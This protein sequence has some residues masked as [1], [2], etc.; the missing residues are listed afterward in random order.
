MPAR[1]SGSPITPAG[2]D[3]ARSARRS[4]RHVGWP[5]GGRNCWPIKYFYVVFT[6]PH[7][8]NP[9]AQGNPRVIYDLKQRYSADDASRRS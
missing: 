6:L 1:R 7:A 3:T 5:R 9:L 2:S 8:L 4:P